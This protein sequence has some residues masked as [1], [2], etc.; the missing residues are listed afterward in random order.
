VRAGKAV[1][2]FFAVQMWWRSRTDRFLEKG[3]Y[4]KFLGETVRL[5]KLLEVVILGKAGQSHV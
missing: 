3:I 2:I 4:A 5:R 1:V